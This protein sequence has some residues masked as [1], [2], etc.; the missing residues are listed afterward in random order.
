MGIYDKTCPQCMAS[1]RAT[2]TRCTCGYLF[3]ASASDERS[4]TLERIAREEKLFEEYLEARLTQAKEVASVAAH[5]AELDP[6]S[7]RKAIEALRANQA[8]AKTAAGL[9]KQRIKAA[10]AAHAAGLSFTMRSALMPDEGSSTKQPSPTQPSSV[11]RPTTP[12]N[13]MT[14]RPSI[15]L[16][17]KDRGTPKHD[18]NRTMPPLRRNDAAPHTQT[19]TSKFATAAGSTLS[20][21][22]APTSNTAG[23]PADN[24]PPIPVLTMAVPQQALTPAPLRNNGVKVFESKMVFDGSPWRDAAKKM[25]AKV[26]RRLA[27]AA[28]HSA[29]KAAKGIGQ[30]AASG[31]KRAGRAAARGASKAA[32]HMAKAAA[33]TAKQAAHAV[34]QRRDAMKVRAARVPPAL[35]PPPTATRPPPTVTNAA[36]KPAVTAGQR[37]N[38]TTTMRAKAAT[39]E[40]APTTVAKRSPP[41]RRVPFP[42]V[43]PA[44][45]STRSVQAKQ[46]AKPTEDFRA[47]QAA[48]IEKAVTA[49]RGL[50]RK[51]PASEIEC[52]LCSATLPANANH[53]LCGWRVP[54]H[55]REI[56]A[57]DLAKPTARDGNEL[58]V[59]FRKIECPLC[60]TTIAVNAKRCQCGWRVPEEVNELP[61]VSLSSEEISALSLGMELDEPSK[62]R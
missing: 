13:G 59:V 11:S 9:A 1:S 58:T 55:E 4:L 5:A 44:T 48:K 24:K 21:P 26:A 43:K 30:A 3:D 29:K 31:A 53:C 62:L 32:K 42:P 6:E 35:D 10:Q 50:E 57:L 27:G 36:V 34:Q 7:R 49:A 39:P 45:A 46:R 61:P 60:S 56:P 18:N 17:P 8:A 25:A 54:N 38:A 12:M 41:P 15:A 2:A 51:L 20:L 22:P 33:H 28:A 14:V 37:R 16:R 40:R 47:M 23:R 52:A 19:V